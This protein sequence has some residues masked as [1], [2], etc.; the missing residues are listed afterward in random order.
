[1]K[2]R[3]NLI[4]LTLILTF[5]LQI[6]FSHAQSSSSQNLINLPIKVASYNLRLDTK[7]DSL[8]AWPYRKDNV[9]ALLNYHDL[10]IIGTQEGYLHQ[11]QDLTSKGNYA[12]SGKGR[13]DGQ[14]AGEHSAI[15]YRKDKFKVLKSGD[16]WLSETPDV[17]GK[18]WDATCCNRIASWVE[19]ED[20]RT[21]NTFYFFNVHFDHKGVV[22]REESGKLMVKKIK[23]IAGEK[24]VICTGDFNS[25][26]ETV[27]IQLMS[28]ALKD[29]YHH[30]E[31]AP[32]GPVGTFTGFKWNASLQDRIDYVFVSE[33]F[34]ILKYAAIT[35]AKN[36]RYPSD[37]L[38]VVVELAFVPFTTR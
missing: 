30:S 36:Q 17:P 25:T 11:L 28:A 34:K 13:D 9:L 20:L 35:D 37:H 24:P 1:M 26:P 38:P 27:Q 14:S 16:F 5:F 10:D 3:D 2:R 8:N 6:S 18:G 12:F 4:A 7:S 29:S 33:A 21:G 23:E 15:L 31:M 19:F 32:Y 22:A